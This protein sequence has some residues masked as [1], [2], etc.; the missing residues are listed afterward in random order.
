MDEKERQL[1]SPEDL[2]SEIPPLAEEPV[3]PMP[4]LVLD[5]PAE[6]LPEE[7]DNLLEPVILCPEIVSEPSS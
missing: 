1:P 4:E 6:S 3:A 2:L 5:S 7:S